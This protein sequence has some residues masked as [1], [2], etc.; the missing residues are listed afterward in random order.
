MRRSPINVRD[1]RQRKSSSIKQLKNSI[2]SAKQNYSSLRKSSKILSLFQEKGVMDLMFQYQEEINRVPFDTLFTLLIATETPA[3]LWNIRNGNIDA[4]TLSR[5][6]YKYVGDLFMS[7]KFMETT[8][9]KHIKNNNFDAIGYAKDVVELY[10]KKFGL[11]ALKYVQFIYVKDGGR[12][13][14]MKI[15]D[16][17]KNVD[18]IVKNLFELGSLSMRKPKIIGF[19]NGYPVLNMTKF[20]KTRYYI[21]KH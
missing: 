10:K 14:K 9:N 11:D 15:L 2:S 1:L 13:K 4:D 5:E 19:E 6:T 3:T 7:Q 21:V 16:D 17:Y 18:K 20:Q 8:I 12:Y